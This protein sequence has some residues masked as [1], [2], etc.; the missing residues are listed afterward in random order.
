MAAADVLHPSVLSFQTAV[1]TVERWV[2][3]EPTDEE[4]LKFLR[5][6]IKDLGEPGNE[7]VFEA[8]MKDL[9]IRAVR[10]DEAFDRVE[11]TMKTF[12]K[13]HGDQFPG[14]K[15]FQEEWSGYTSVRYC[16]TCVSLSEATFR[17]GE[18]K[19]LPHEILR[20]KPLRHMTVPFCILLVLTCIYSCLEL[21]L[22][23][24]A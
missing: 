23:N 17:H 5:Q 4:K 6:A 22:Y 18:M 13:D 11:R 19:S 24:T 20:R 16:P 9:G 8:A 21:R 14:L 1:K 2:Q 15:P 12:V 3:E 7:Q 10:T